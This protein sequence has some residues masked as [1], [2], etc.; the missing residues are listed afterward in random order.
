M[1]LSSL[2]QSFLH[3]VGEH[4]DVSTVML[5]IGIGLG[6]GVWRLLK[7]HFSE[8][9]VRRMTELFQESRIEALEI[10]VYDSVLKLKGTT[11]GQ[12]VVQ[13]GTI[14]GTK[15]PPIGLQYSFEKGALLPTPSQ[16][17]FEDEGADCY[18]YKPPFQGHPESPTFFL[19]PRKSTVRRVLEG[20][21]IEVE[22]FPVRPLIIEHGGTW[23]FV[24]IDPK[25]NLPDL[26]PLQGKKPKGW[27]G[28]R[29][30]KRTREVY[31]GECFYTDEV[32]GWVREVRNDRTIAIHQYR[33]PAP[34]YYHV[35]NVF[36]ETEVVPGHLACLLVEI[37]GVVE[38]KSPGVGTLNLSIPAGT[39][40][41]TERNTEVGQYVPSNG[42]I[43]RIEALGLENAHK[44]VSPIAGR[45]IRIDASDGD[46][47]EYGQLL[48]LIKPSIRAPK[49]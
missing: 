20:G 48:F 49:A 10:Q 47:V 26:S 21:R 30:Q 39:E 42:L 29:R 15:I 44:M 45:I 22:S 41:L 19:I 31:F 34:V 13:E 33:A 7:G 8:P 32:I 4:W 2:I 24:R 35:P 5:I 36:P 1:S 37:P 40:G 38:V 6:V 27:Y 18:W 12:K 23:T 9:R 43:G 11:P 17:L 25:T 3:V 16:V 14:H 28:S 46:P